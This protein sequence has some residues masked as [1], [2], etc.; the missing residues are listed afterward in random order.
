MKKYIIDLGII[1]IFLLILNIKP[2]Y[3]YTDNNKKQLN[4][5]SNEL[6][7]YIETND[8]K[9]IKSICSNDFCSY[10]KSQNIKRA[11]EIFKQEFADYLKQEKDEDLVTSTIIKGFPITEIHL[12]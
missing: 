1:L 8:L 5:L 6:L 10:L 2:T 9:N 4:I 3:G 7:N 12:N 11:I